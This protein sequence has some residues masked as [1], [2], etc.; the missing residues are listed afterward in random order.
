MGACVLFTVF[1]VTVL[2]TNIYISES[3]VIF[4]K[5]LIG[6]GILAVL[7]AI[8]HINTIK[9]HILDYIAILWFVYATF[10]YYFLSI[11]PAGKDYINICSTFILY[12][13][14]R[15]LLIGSRSL[16]KYTVLLFACFGLY[17]AILGL[18]QL[19]GF[20]QSNHNLFKITG[21]L[22]NPGPYSAYLAMVF[23]VCGVYIYKRRKL[24]TL[25]NFFVIKSFKNPINYYSIINKFIFV[26][27]TL[28]ISTII[29]ALPATLSR[30]AFVSI[31]A[32]VIV[33]LFKEYK[34]IIVPAL[35]LMSIAGVIL[36]F[37]KQD[38]ANG[39]IFMWIISVLIIKNNLLFGTGIG[40]YQHG[41]SLAQVEFFKNNPS[42]NFVDVAGSPE[43]AFNDILFV[44]AEQGIIGLGLFIAIIIISVQCLLRYKTEL[45]YGWLALLVVS[46]FSYPFYLLPY[47]VFA[48]VFV[49][50][51]ASCP[52]QQKW[53]SKLLIKKVAKIQFYKLTACVVIV[54]MSIILLN[55]I[56]QKFEANK[57]FTY[58]NYAETDYIEDIYLD[59]INIMGDNPDFLFRYGK[60]LNRLGLYNESNAVLRKSAL[61]CNDNIIYIIMG[62]NYKALKCYDLAENAYKTA[63]QMEPRKM[64]PLYLLLQLYE[65]WNKQEKG[66]D[67]AKKILKYNPKNIFTATQEMKEYAKKYLDNTN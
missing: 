2:G 40:G 8:L 27:C 30:A 54:V 62:N 32:V 53:H 59:W 26:I 13:E 29:I 20:S 22:F 36:Y 1:Y 56:E 47:R 52:M 55:K 6:L 46:L 57:A 24:Y 34:K 45:G 16:M 5:V 43:F 51:A 49:A 39:R 65:T 63:S 10:N 14:L 61:I 11:Y 44:G 9:P 37:F 3:D 4:S 50:M 35:I 41:Y 64:Y 15:L 12:L 42:S 66:K 7:N 28:A 38:S 23:A 21:T 25:S 19:Y 33:L 17:E 18:M 48:V 58:S 31:F 67:V 60:K